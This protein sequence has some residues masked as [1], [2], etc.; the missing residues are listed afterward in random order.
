MNENEV[1]ETNESKNNENQ[2]QAENTIPEAEQKESSVKNKKPK[3]I[4]KNEQELNHLK[5]ELSEW[6]EKYEA[7]NDKHLRLAAEFDNYKK[8]TLKEKSDLL[9]YGGETVLTNLLQ[10]I[11]DIERANMSI[12]TSTDIDSIKNGIELIF[13][14]FNEFLKQQGVKEIETKDA[15][16]NTDVHEAVT[17]IPATCEEQKGKVVDVIQKGYMLQDKVIRFAKVVVGE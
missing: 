12:K 14:K 13:S 15:V 3:K 9:R 7:L 16:F 10:I 17:R 5:K 11:D 2:Q 6:K 4:N 8:R 1:I